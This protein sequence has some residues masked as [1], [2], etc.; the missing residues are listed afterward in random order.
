MFNISDG[1]QTFTHTHKRTHTYTHTLTHTHTHTYTQLPIMVIGGVFLFMGFGAL[2]GNQFVNRIKL[3]FMD[4]Q[5]FPRRTLKLKRRT[6]HLFTG[7]QLLCLVVLWV[8]K[9]SIIALTFPLFLAMLLP[10]RAFLARRVF[11]AHDMELLDGS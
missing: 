1:E 6:I 2:R 4:P 7:I 8:I 5:S 10:L 9:S 3:F 11:T